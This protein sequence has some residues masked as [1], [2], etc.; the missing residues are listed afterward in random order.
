MRTW[1]AC[2][3]GPHP[4]SAML[5]RTHQPQDMDSW[6]VCACIEKR[7]RHIG[8]IRTKP[9]RVCIRW[10]QRWPISRGKNPPRAR[11]SLRRE[12]AG[13]AFEK[14]QFSVRFVCA[15]FG[16]QQRLLLQ[17]KLHFPPHEPAREGRRVC[18][19][20]SE[21]VIERW[22]RCRCT[23]NNGDSARSEGS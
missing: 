14:S 22:V 19:S 16:Y 7:S 4:R 12:T 23:R 2:G 5:L 8:A 1:L 15:A 20:G 18:C 17:S 10:G 6:S 9:R 21:T 3:Q 13:S 11:V